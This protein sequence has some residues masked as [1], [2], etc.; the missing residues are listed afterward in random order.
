MRRQSSTT[1]TALWATV[2]A[3]NNLTSRW[4]ATADA[5]RGTVFS[6]PG[7][8]PLLAFL[9]DGADGAARTELADAVGLRA[10]ETAAA[11]RDL[12]AAM[13]GVR[14]VDAAL[15]LW[16]KRTLTLRDAWRDGV[17]VDAL[18]VLTGDPAAD[19]ATLDAWA[20]ERTG[21][22]IER[23]RAELTPDTELVLASA[24]ALR[25]DWTTPFEQHLLE[26]ATGPWRGL[27]IAGLQRSAPG[28]DAVRTGRHPAGRVT[29]VTVGG[30]ADV[31]VHLLLGDAHLGP[32]EVLPTGLGMLMDDVPTTS[33]SEL[34]PGPAGPGAVLRETLA[35]APDEPPHVALSTVGFTVDAEHDLQAPPGLFGLEAASVPRPGSFPGI[36]DRPLTVESARQ[37]ATATFGAAGFRAGAVTAVAMDWMGLPSY[38]T[39]ELAVTVD[40]PFGFLAVHRTSRLVLAAGWVTDPEPYR[41]DE[42]Y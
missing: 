10:D 21:G 18:G 8:W 2:Q 30:T 25:T 22:Q 13:N 36:S 11:A 31:D 4:A 14:G 34:P 1:R 39:T 35:D 33:G 16:T 42:G 26:P 23:M 41:E 19:A 15:G 29:E 27:R 28:L 24:L 37:T 7:V 9:A 32:C 40:R 12:L 20:A 17:P 3:V 6:A 38:A 5:D